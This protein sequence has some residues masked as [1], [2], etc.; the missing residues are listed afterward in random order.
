MRST[1]FL[2]IALAV[3]GAI[4]IAGRHLQHIGYRA[5]PGLDI[6]QIEPGTTARV[7]AARLSHGNMEGLDVQLFD[8]DSQHY[9]EVRASRGSMR[10]DGRLVIPGNAEIA[11]NVAVN[12]VKPPA[13]TGVHDVTF[14]SRSNTLAYRNSK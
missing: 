7:T 14:D 13:F 3:I 5:T 4:I 12:A 2:L 10:D 6:R 11:Y 1:R 9:M 8:P